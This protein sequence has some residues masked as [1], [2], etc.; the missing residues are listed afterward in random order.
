MTAGVVVGGVFLTGNQ[1][2]GMVELLVGAGSDFIDDG[3]FQVHEK[4]ARDVLAG[5]RL[6]EE[7]VERVVAN[8]LGLV[9]WH[10]S[11]GLDAVFQAIQLPAG[12]AHLDTGLSDVDRD[13]FPHDEW[14]RSGV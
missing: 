11:V 3:G 13:D 14:I 4:G 10:L 2:L 12:V 5:P 6:A 8:A 7:R 1:L 9:G